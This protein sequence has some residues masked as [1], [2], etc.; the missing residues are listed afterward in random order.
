[1]I[2]EESTI[3]LDFQILEEEC[4]KIKEIIISTNE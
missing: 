1:M 4:Q 2:S 3:Q